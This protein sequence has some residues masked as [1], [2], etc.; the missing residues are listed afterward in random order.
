LRETQM[1][2]ISSPLIISLAPSVKLKKCAGIFNSYGK[3][4]NAPPLISG[5]MIY[6]NTVYTCS[7]DRLAS[8]ASEMVQFLQLKSVPI[9]PGYK[10][11]TCSYIY[12]CW[13]CCRSAR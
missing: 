4:P 10:R 8:R 2:W 7:D 3:S 12:I 1:A 13:V 5:Q 6:Q 11:K 9:L